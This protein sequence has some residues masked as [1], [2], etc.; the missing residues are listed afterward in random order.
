VC[1]A[2]AM[3]VKFVCSYCYSPKGAVGSR[4]PSEGSPVPA[5]NLARVKGI[6]T[7]NQGLPNAVEKKLLA[8]RQLQKWIPQQLRKSQRRRMSKDTKLC[9]SRSGTFL[10]AKAATHCVPTGK[11]LRSGDPDRREQFKYIAAPRTVFADRLPVILASLQK[12]RSS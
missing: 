3:L 1:A 6:R 8:I 11:A 5:E 10:A 7:S 4:I 2:E 9:T 12:R